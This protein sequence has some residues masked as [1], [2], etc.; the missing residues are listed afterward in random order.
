MRDKS[1][2]LQIIFGIIQEYFSSFRN[3]KDNVNEKL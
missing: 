1:G 2:I 3:K